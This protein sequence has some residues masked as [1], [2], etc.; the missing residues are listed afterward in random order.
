M[1]EPAH[2]SCIR[3]GR[4][5][6]GR[7]SLA[8]L[9]HLGCYRCRRLLILDGV[10]GGKRIVAGRR[11]AGHDDDIALWLAWGAVIGSAAQFLVQLPTVILLLRSL[12]PVRRP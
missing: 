8:N 10:G 2:A 3:V 11:L 4:F 9:L 5:D 12:R 6:R 1:K 7:L